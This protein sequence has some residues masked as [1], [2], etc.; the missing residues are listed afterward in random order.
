MM[1]KILLSFA[2]FGVVL[3]S[4]SLANAQSFTSL[5]AQLFELNQKMENFKLENTAAVLGAV[6]TQPKVTLTASPSLLP[7]SATGSTT[8]TWTST[9][10]TSCSWGGDDMADDQW[11]LPKDKGIQG[12]KVINNLTWAGYWFKINCEGPE[13]YASAEVR[14]EFVPDIQFSA[15]PTTVNSLGNTVL[16]W[17]A[18]KVAQLGRNPACKASGSW[19]GNKSSSGSQVISR[20]KSDQ[21][22]TLICYS[23][24]GKAYSKTIKVKVTKPESQIPVSGAKL[25]V[26]VSDT[27][28]DDASVISVSSSGACAFTFKKALSFGSR[29]SKTSKEVALLQ[30]ILVDEGL[31]PVKDTT[32][33]FYSRTEAALKKFQQKYQLSQTGRLDTQTMQKMNESFAQYC[34]SY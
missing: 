19:S 5:K 13:G 11:R 2:L 15:S 4:P 23:A 1:K 27:V 29:D 18:D 24:S 12:S 32:G 9:G 10:A 25:D 3:S 31:L 34:T 26:V 8:L 7:Y 21:T 6:S 20:L 33:V 30:S 14:V 17:K 16:T 22:F 28:V